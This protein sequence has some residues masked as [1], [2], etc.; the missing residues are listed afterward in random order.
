MERTA[1][2]KCA[3]ST[4][5][6]LN[7]D[8]CMCACACDESRGVEHVDDDVCVLVPLLTM[9]FG[10]DLIRLCCGT[11]VMMYVWVSYIHTY[12]HTCMYVESMYVCTYVCMRCTHTLQLTL[13]VVEWRRSVLSVVCDRACRSCTVLEVWSNKV[14]LW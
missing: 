2:T 3:P 13:M 8:V 14:M 9:A 5:R 12:I 7:Y 4:N 10:V 11:T 6:W 1:A